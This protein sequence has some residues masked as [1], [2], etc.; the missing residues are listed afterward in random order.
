MNE[1]DLKSGNEI[2]AKLKQLKQSLYS[3]YWPKLSSDGC[4]TDEL[5]L[6]QSRKPAIII[7]YDDIDEDMIRSQIKLP[8]ILNE[9]LI[10]QI[11][12][13]IKSEITKLQTEFNRL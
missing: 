13:L 10:E 4:P 7:E 9:K 3:F 6:T 5:N 1:K 11:E 2:Q 8:I 12:E